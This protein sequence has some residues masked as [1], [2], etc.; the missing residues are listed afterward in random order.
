MRPQRG[1]PT[2]EDVG[3]SIKRSVCTQVCTKHQETT[4]GEH[5]AR[6][7]ASPFL[8]A[9]ARR[10]ITFLSL[11]F[12]TPNGAVDI[13]PIERRATLAFEEFGPCRFGLL[14]REAVA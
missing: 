4:C 13:N 14:D 1:G 5:I 8:P 9:T 6:G 2:R 12:I 7:H 10:Q 11:F 3:T